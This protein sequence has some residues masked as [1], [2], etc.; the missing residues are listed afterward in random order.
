MKYE[1]VNSP[2]E[3]MSF[4]NS[5]EYGFVDSAGNKYGSWNEDEFEKNVQT[6][7]HLSSPERLIEVG[8]GHCFDQV[9]LERDWFSKHNYNYKTF[10]IMFLFDHPNDY[11]THT[12]LVYEDNNKWYLFEHS[13][14]YDRGIHEFNSLK[15]ALIY[16]MNLHIEYNKKYNQVGEEE[17]NHLRV[18][19]YDKPIS[20][21][22]F[23]DFIDFIL[24][25]GKDITPILDK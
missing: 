24:D 14:F 13:D 5:I 21:L 25:N 3:L 8:Y 20:N 23:N 19:E 10:Y 7:W 15:D 16:K 2:N 17:I 1:N 11:S 6:K 22:S 18:F 4:M 9:E 12:F